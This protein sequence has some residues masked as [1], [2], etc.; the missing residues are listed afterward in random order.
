M[1]TASRDAVRVAIVGGGITGAVAA[2]TLSAAGVEVHVFDQGRRGPGGRASHRS[3]RPSDRSVLGD[4]G[5][6]P[7]DGWEFDHGCQFL[8][9]DTPRMRGLCKEWCDRGWAAPW[10][11]RFGRAP[12]EVSV[13]FFGLPTDSSPVYV[14]VG[15]MQRL[16]RAILGASAAIVHAGVRVGGLSR[17][18]GDDAQWE[19]AGVSGPAAFHDTAEAVAAAAQPQSLGRFDAVLLTDVS[20]SFES[21]HRASAGV[22]EA[23]ADQ[24]RHRVRVPLFSCMVVLAEPLQLPLD[25][26]TFGS[27]EHGGLWWAARSTSKPGLGRRPGGHAGG[28]ETGSQRHG[29]GCAG[30]AGE[31]W[32]L[33]ST[34]SF[35]VDEI[36]RVHMQDPETGAFRPQEDGYLNSGPGAALY[37]AFVA[38]V[39]SMI[40]AGAPPPPATPLYLQGQRW[41]SAF[42]APA[43]V[44]GRDA[45]GHGPTTRTVLRVAYESAVPPLVYESATTPPA[46]EPVGPPSKDF[47]ADDDLKMYYAGDYCSRRPPGFEAACLSGIEAAEHIAATLVGGGCSVSV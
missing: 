47:V 12:G 38:G 46:H 6:V 4:D 3:V 26:I 41:G 33:I 25:G 45:R 8:R 1:S 28:A 43:L 18:D 2:S 24:L 32:T 39:A 22:P 23:L 21:W 30:G 31:C 11:G 37:A 35:A 34:P 17:A 19:L 40:P 42:P 29:D 44:E 5:P 7:E 13:D 14:G 27:A 16:P 15:G 36:D 10:S 9:A 20:S